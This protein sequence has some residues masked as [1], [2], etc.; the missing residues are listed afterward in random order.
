M[1]IIKNKLRVISLMLSADLALVSI[2]ADAFTLV[3]TWKLLDIEHQTATGQWEPD[4]VAPQGLLT[5]TASGYM[6]VGINC[7]QNKTSHQPSYRPQ[8][9]TFYTG[10][11]R[12]KGNHITHIVQNSSSPAFYGKHL[13][14]TLQCLNADEMVLNAIEPNGQKV[15]LQWRKIGS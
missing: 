6:A 12:L 15:K 5:Y 10:T 14:R 7:M 4:C 1:S 9:L 3:G 8:D 2:H 13:E 11:Y